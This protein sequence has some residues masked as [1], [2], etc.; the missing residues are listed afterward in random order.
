MEDWEAHF[1]DKSRRRARRRSRAKV[2]KVGVL[3]LLFSSI[4]T[5]TYLKMVGF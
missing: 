5:A 4:L 1:R 2:V 3:T